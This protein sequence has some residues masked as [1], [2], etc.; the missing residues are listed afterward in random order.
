MGARNVHKEEKNIFKLPVEA[1]AEDRGLSF[2]EVPQLVVASLEDAAYYKNDRTSFAFK[3][4]SMDVYLVD[5]SGNEYEAPG[6]AIA[7][8]YQSDAVGFVI[9]WRQVVEGGTLIQGCWRVKVYWNIAGNT[10]FF[11]YGSY[12]LKEYS[13][14]NVRGTVRLFVVLNDLVRKQGINY[15]D[16]GFAGTVRFKGFFGDMQP[17]Y[18]TENII[19]TDRTREK[20]R[21]EALRTYEL[22]SNYLLHCMTRLIDE[23]H[24]L[25]ANQIYISDHNAQNHVQNYYDFPVVLSQEESP[26]FDYTGTVYAKITALFNDKVQVHESKYDGNI[27]GSSNIILSLPTIVSSPTPCADADVTV[28]GEAFG[29]AP[30]GG[31]LDVLVKASDGDSVGALAGSVWSIGDSEVSINSTVVANVPATDSLGIAVELDG[32]PAGTWNAGTQTWEVTGVAPDYNSAELMKT[33]QTSS[34]ATNDDG[35]LQKGRGTSFFVLSHNTPFGNTNRFTS[36]NYAAQTTYTNKIMID[37]STYRNGL[38]TGYYF[39]QMDGTNRAWGAA[40]AWGA[41]LSVAGFTS[42]WRLTNDLELFNIR[43]AGAVYALH[44]APL[45]SFGLL[46]VG[47]WSST[48]SD[49]SNAFRLYNIDKGLAPIG[50]ANLLRC[51]ACRTF[52]VTGTALT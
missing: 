48:Q 10:G 2:C 14:F 47:F 49:A 32:S 27:K 7:F 13:P 42:G 8:P 39:G 51:I 21:N 18:D 15:K 20:V 31:S 12:D 34:G 43:N 38:V 6:T 40:V 45:N 4:D 19:Y 11:W 50:K 5:A 1:I 16:S 26:K 9:D 23:E 44:Y 36:D 29:S 17:N 33:G 35:N 37:W 25:A 24:L 30:S 46:S 28:N 41:A 22:R 52:T 3:F